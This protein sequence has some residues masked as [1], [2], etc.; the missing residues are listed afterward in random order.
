MPQ[1]VRHVVREWWSED[2]RLLAVLGEALRGAGAVPREFVDAGKAARA[3]SDLDAELAALV[4]DSASDAGL[5]T[6]L[7][8]DDAAPLH[9]LMFA[10]ATL[11]IEVELLPGA[12]FGQVIPAERGRVAALLSGG[13]TA[14][15]DIDDL[16]CFVLRPAPGC[17]I[18]LYCTTASGVSA[19]TGWITARTQA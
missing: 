3:W 1:R 9:T 16:G 2:D 6:T 4:Y 13:Q 8:S 7:R 17:R 14:H 12:L 5:A 15:A 18:R 10:S 19:L 11:T